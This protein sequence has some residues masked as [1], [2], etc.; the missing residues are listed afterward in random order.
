MQLLFCVFAVLIFVIMGLLPWIIPSF[1]SKETKE[2]I[3][4]RRP[5]L[6]LSGIISLITVG[7]TLAVG[8]LSFEW[9]NQENL[10]SLI[11]LSVEIIPLILMVLNLVW[12]ITLVLSAKK[13]L[14]NN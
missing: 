12:V 7:I 13:E 4:H 6:I 8:F 14:K 10:F 9:R 2:Q 3:G 11:P 1:C 5:F